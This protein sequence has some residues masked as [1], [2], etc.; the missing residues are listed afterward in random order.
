MGEQLRRQIAQTRS[1]APSFAMVDPRF[2][3]PDLHDPMFIKIVG[4]G[5]GC[6]VLSLLVFHRTLR[7]PTI[8]IPNLFLL[9]G[10]VSPFFFMEQLAIPGNEAASPFDYKTTVTGF[11]QR[12]HFC[13]LRLARW[14]NYQ[15]ISNPLGGP[16][17]NAFAVLGMLFASK[18]GTF[19][20]LRGISFLG[21]LFIHGKWAV[22]IAQQIFVDNKTPAAVFASF[23]TDAMTTM[24]DTPAFAGVQNGTKG[25]MP[26]SY[27][28]DYFGMVA[29]AL[30]YA[31]FEAPTIVD[32][33]KAVLITLCGGGGVGLLWA[34]QQSMVFAPNSSSSRFLAFLYLGTAAACVYVWLP[35][36]MHW[37]DFAVTPHGRL[38]GG[39]INDNVKMCTLNVVAPY[40]ALC[41]MAIA[42]YN[43]QN[44]SIFTKGV[45]YFNACAFLFFHIAAA[46]AIMM[47]M[48]CF[49][50][51][52]TL[53]A[54]A[55]EAKAAD[56]K[57]KK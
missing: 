39:M 36:Q 31:I 37:I 51:K 19:S 33:I 34:F 6:F 46:T 22:G 4:M 23:W 12:D 52:S 27:T 16:L 20:Y 44:L 7:H 3:L 54:A 47:G 40:F 55:S 45:L 24:S 41:G 29:V 21:C 17:I 26:A 15:A 28:V 48:A 53:E 49:W 43:R 1:L 14:Y 13:L 50:G 9:A 25:Y 35:F 57:K 18:G 32:K 8:I 5:Y 38:N 10:L 11:I 42:Y 30:V 2:V 56:A